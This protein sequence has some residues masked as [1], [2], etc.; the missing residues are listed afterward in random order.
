MWS[1]QVNVS[2][3]IGLLEFYWLDTSTDWLFQE[4][5]NR[6]IAVNVLTYLLHNPH[7]TLIKL[8]LKGMQLPLRLP[9]KTFGEYT[10]QLTY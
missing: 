3:V 9:G 2:L 5:A 8:I 7:K 6:F 4:S 10:I 1:R